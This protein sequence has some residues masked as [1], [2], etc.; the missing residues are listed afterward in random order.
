MK[1]FTQAD[2]NK[3]VDA[4]TRRIKMPVGDYSDVEFY[5]MRGLDF[6][7]WH[8][9]DESIIGD[10]ADIGVGSR[11]QKCVA[12]SKCRFK[13]SSIEYYSKCGDDCE[14]IDCD[15]D[16]WGTVTIGNNARFRHCIIYSLT[17]IGEGAEIS[18]DT[19]LK[20]VRLQYATLI[21]DSKIEGGSLIECDGACN[22]RL[23]DV[24]LVAS[25][26][27]GGSVLT[28]CRF[29]SKKYAEDDWRS[30]NIV[31]CVVTDCAFGQR[32]VVRNC[33]VIGGTA[34][35]YC[36]FIDCDIFAVDMDETCVVTNTMKKKEL[37]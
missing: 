28:K 17:Y 16:A 25:G 14:F 1:K 10:G 21:A 6:G 13:G 27:T 11:L 29:V 31:D 33:R 3:L 26:V 5:G 18:D 32:T 30:C 8:Y 12:G 15:I 24:V 2:F 9:E 22:C 36:E 19:V 37:I 35:R 4:G 23:S 7:R 20:N 34:D